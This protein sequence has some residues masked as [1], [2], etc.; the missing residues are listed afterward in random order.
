MDDLNGT[1]VC[2]A[3]AELAPTPNR[4]SASTTANGSSRLRFLELLSFLFHNVCMGILL[5]RGVRPEVPGCRRPYEFPVPRT[6]G[7]LPISVED[8]KE[9]AAGLVSKP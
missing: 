1:D 8:G 9:V 6:S 2:A 4:V 5:V 7:G 3:L